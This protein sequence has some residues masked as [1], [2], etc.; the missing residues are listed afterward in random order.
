MNSWYSIRTKS[1][2][3]FNM[4]GSDGHPIPG[5]FKSAS[6]RFDGKLPDYKNEKLAF[7]EVLR[8]DGKFY[9]EQTNGKVQK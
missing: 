3:Q 9:F 5:Q 8:K 4:Y 1:Y 6:M 2:Y 7:Y